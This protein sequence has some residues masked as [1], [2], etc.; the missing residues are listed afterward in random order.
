MFHIRFLTWLM[1]VDV[2]LPVFKLCFDYYR[3]I[4]SDRRL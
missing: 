1:D 3:L 4:G 2:N